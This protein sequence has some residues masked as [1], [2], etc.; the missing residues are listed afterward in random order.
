[1][2]ATRE[3]KLDKSQRSTPPRCAAKAPVSRGLC[4]HGIK[5]E[6]QQ[7]HSYGMVHRS[8]IRT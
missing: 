8:H 4:G 3:L 2:N 5:E 7:L 1:M 6:S